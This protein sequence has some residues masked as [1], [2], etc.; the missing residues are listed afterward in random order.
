MIN[1]IYFDLDQCL[2]HSSVNVD[3]KQ[4]CLVHNYNDWDDRKRKM[5]DNTYYTIIRPCA[6]GLFDFARGL[7][8]EDR[9]YILTDSVLDYATT[10]NNHAQFVDPT[11]LLTREDIDRHKVFGAY[12]GSNILQHSTADR[13]NVLVDNLPSRYNERKTSFLGIMDHSRYLQVRDYWG[14]NFPD[15]PFEEDVKQFLNKLHHA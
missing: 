15:D 5:V 13:N 12:G 8:G 7:I 14:V 9:V 10:I 3:P 1:N 6:K 2:L 11:K 4:S